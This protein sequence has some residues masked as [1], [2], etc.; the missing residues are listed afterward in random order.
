VISGL[1]GIG[2]SEL[3]CA[4]AHAVQVNY[5]QVIWIDAAPLERAGQPS[6]DGHSASADVDNSGH[7]RRK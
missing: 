4:V 6:R 1:G 7:H 3:A 2:K 5:V